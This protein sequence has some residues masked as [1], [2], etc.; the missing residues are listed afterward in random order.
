MNPFRCS[1][2][3]SAFAKT[4]RN[5]TELLRAHGLLLNQIQRKTR[6]GH[7]II[8]KRYQEEDLQDAALDKSTNEDTS[9]VKIYVGNRTKTASVSGDLQTNNTIC[10]E[11]GK[12]VIHCEWV[13]VVSPACSTQAP[14]EP[15]RVLPGGVKASHTDNPRLCAACVTDGATSENVRTRHLQ[16]IVKVTNGLIDE[17]LLPKPWSAGK[18]NWWAVTFEWQHGPPQSCTPTRPLYPGDR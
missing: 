3:F 9:V 8:Y 15:N 4:T 17:H 7:L 14:P 6:L 1:I 18:H 12:N 13:G 10:N 2:P 16:T 11:M 5:Q